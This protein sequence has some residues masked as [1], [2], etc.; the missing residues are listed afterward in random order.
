MTCKQNKLSK[1][2][3]EQLKKREALKHTD[4]YREKL[5]RHQLKQMC[6]EEARISQAKYN[7][8]KIRVKKKVL[9]MI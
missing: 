4:E 5:L 1:E 9:E 2:E 3:K 6:E 7:W 8:Q